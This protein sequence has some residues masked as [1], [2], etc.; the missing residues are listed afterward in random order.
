MKKTAFLLMSLFLFTMTAHA[1][2]YSY[3]GD[4]PIFT[5]SFPDDWTIETE[6]E[7]LHAMPADE[8]IYVGVWAIDSIDDVDLVMEALDEEIASFIED[9]ETGE[10]VET[11]INDIPFIIVEGDG[12][13]ED[14]I[15]VEFSAA[16]FST[17]GETF[18]VA[19]Y[20]G[21]PEM[22]EAYGEEL[23]DILYSVSIPE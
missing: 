5:I 22:V 21:T 17:D 8:S 23:D 4:D 16:L 13:V 7:L 18:F 9:I 10:P 20:F 14:D 11:E 12:F 6:D 3:P 19:L 15:Q 2:T 1:D